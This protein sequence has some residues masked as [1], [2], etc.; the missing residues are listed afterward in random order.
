MGDDN[1]QPRRRSEDGYVGFDDDHEPRAAGAFSTV[2]PLV[3][4]VGTALANVAHLALGALASLVAAAAL[5]PLMRRRHGAGPSLPRMS[6]PA[7][8]GPQDRSDPS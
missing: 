4:R 6:G 1:A 3:I 5:V 7:R 8:P 2:I